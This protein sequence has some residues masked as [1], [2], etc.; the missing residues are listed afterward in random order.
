[1]A[2]EKGRASMTPAGE[3]PLWKLWGLREA[4]TGTKKHSYSKNENSKRKL[5]KK[6]KQKSE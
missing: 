1:M 6:K 2:V 4:D 5:R 3:E